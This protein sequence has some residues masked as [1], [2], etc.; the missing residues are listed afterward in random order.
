MGS[1]LLVF[2]LVSHPRLPQ[3]ASCL[4]SSVRPSRTARRPLLP[5]FNR[6]VKRLVR[7]VRLPVP[8]DLSD[9]RLDIA[10]SLSAPPSTTCLPS[11]TQNHGRSFLNTRLFKP[12]KNLSTPRRRNHGELPSLLSC[13]LLLVEPL[14]LPSSSSHSLVFPHLM[15]SMP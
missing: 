15:L 5:Q 2:L 6:P 12:G 14:P 7:L 10:S 1:L 4:P 8:A 11:T 9:S 3:S 13:L